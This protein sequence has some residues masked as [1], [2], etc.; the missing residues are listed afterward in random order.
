MSKNP[1]SLAVSNKLGASLVSDK[2]HTPSSIP[3]ELLKDL[4]KQS[5]LVS[6][7]VNSNNK[8]SDNLRSP[9]NSNV[10]GMSTGDNGMYQNTTSISPTAVSLPGISIDLIIYIK[11]LIENHV[12][13][14]VIA[15]PISTTDSNTVDSSKLN[16]RLKEM[17]KER[18]TSFREAV[19]L[20]T[21]FKV[22][23]YTAES[24]GAEAGGKRLRLRSIYAES[25]DDSLLF[26]VSL[27]VYRIRVSL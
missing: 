26:Q 9:G 19:Y 11:H 22:D 6:K 16:L 21:G 5:K 24:D 17:F 8:D 2:L 3:I 27:F 25:P 12:I 23:L 18:I 14:V 10:N 13:T 20:L 7:S 15:I 1:Y 4:K